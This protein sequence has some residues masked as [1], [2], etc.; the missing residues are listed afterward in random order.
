MTRTERTKAYNQA[1]PEHQRAAQK[2]MEEVVTRST[3]D[4]AFR[5]LLLSNPRAAF[6]SHSGVSESVIPESFNISFVENTATAT[7]VLPD[8]VGS[9]ELAEQELETVAGG[10]EVIYGEIALAAVLAYDAIKEA[11]ELGKNAK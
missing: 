5:D 8:P 3:T 10:T 4:R 9:G 1:S 11:Y 7:V 2:M 6:A